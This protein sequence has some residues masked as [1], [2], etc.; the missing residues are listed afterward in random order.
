MGVVQI[1]VVIV[2]AHSVPQE[3][4]AVPLPAE[5]MLWPLPLHLTA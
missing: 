1:D 4:T 3:H 2:S 5:Q